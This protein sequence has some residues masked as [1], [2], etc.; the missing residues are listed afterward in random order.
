MDSWMK[1]EA[2]GKGKLHARET[3]S[4]CTSMRMKAAQTSIHAEFQ[5]VFLFKII[6]TKR[7]EEM[8][9]RREKYNFMNVTIFLMMVFIKKEK[10]NDLKTSQRRKKGKRKEGIRCIRM[11]IV[12]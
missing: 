5:K 3:E 8:R 6:D 10:K 11:K 9:R 1:K 2:L 12:L 4:P 7:N